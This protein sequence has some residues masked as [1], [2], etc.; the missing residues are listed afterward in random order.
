ML[1]LSMTFR[2][3]IFVKSKILSSNEEKSTFWSIISLLRL[4]ILFVEKN[5]TVKTTYF[6]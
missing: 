5:L 6:N 3:N 4:K 1:I 2:F